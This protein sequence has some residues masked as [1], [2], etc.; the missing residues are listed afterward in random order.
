MSLTVSGREPRPAAPRHDSGSASLMR[1]WHTIRHLHGVQIYGRLR[2]R[3]VHPR[4]DPAP[5]PPSRAAAGNWQR[6]QPRPPVLTAPGRFDLLN[7]AGSLD[8]DGWDN[9]ARAKLW[10]YHQHYFDD[11]TAE[12][13]DRRRQWHR[14]LIDDWIDDNP[15]G[16]G[17]GWEPY[18]TSRR[19]V[20]WIKWALGGHPLGERAAGSLAIQVRWLSRHLEWHILGNHV[21]AN[22]KALI[23][24]GLFFEGPEAARWRRTGGAVLAAQLPAQLLADGGHFERSPMYHAL[25]LE[26]LLDLINIIAA[27]GA[28]DQLAIAIGNR[29]PQMLGWLD[30][31]C[32]GDGEIA[33]F[34]DAAFGMA[35]TAAALHRYAQALA[36]QAPKLHLPACAHLQA[37]GYVRMQ[38]GDGVVLADVAP[39]GPD[40]LPG[41]AHADTLAFELSLGSQRVI[42]NGG[43]SLYGVGA[44]RHRQ[45]STAAHS[46]VEI[47]G[48]NSS[49]VWA[50]FRV[51]RRARIHDVQ[52]VRAGAD[53]YLS[54]WHD[55][56]RHR[57][58]RPAH[59]RRWWLGP[60]RLTVEDTITGSFDNAFARYHLHPGAS[61]AVHGTGHG[62]IRL[63]DGRTIGW[64]SD[65]ATRV[66]PSTWHP[67]FGRTIQA[68]Q[69]VLPFAGPGRRIIFQW[70]AKPCTSSF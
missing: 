10:R 6:P 23:F 68:Q 35:L 49:D 42:V 17:T 5:P 53:A 56:Y 13:A 66:E 19:I 8:K 60:G 32:H 29:V 58:G 51:G 55:G 37:S 52:M 64:H 45:R 9:P 38:A 46:T 11:L 4:I 59:Q 43:T 39:V 69:L 27:Y 63:A 26:D 7:E 34:N 36:V 48:A 65:G 25:V 28:A 67:Q 16:K 62:T 21:L 2:S 24:A 3:I 50:G 22:A 57:P 14:A 33:F 1:Y 40:H 18:P 61:L 12:G 47:D 54:A 44:E 15:P 30:V 20:N 70:E 41:H 31:M